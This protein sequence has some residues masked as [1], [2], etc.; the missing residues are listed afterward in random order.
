MLRRVGRCGRSRRCPS[1][2][3]RSCRIF[4]RAISSCRSEL[5][6]RHIARR[7]AECRA[8]A[9]A[10]KC[11]RCPTCEIVEQQVGRAELGEDT[12]GPHRSEFH[13]ELKAD[14]TVDQS[15][16]SGSN[17]A[18]SCSTI[19]GCRARWS[20]FSGDR[21]SES[22]SGVDRAGGDQDI[23]R[24]PRRARSNSAGKVVAALGKVK[25][26]VDLQFKRQS[27]TPGDLHP[28]GS[29]GAGGDRPQGAGRSRDHRDG[30]CGRQGRARRFR[31]PVPSMSWCC[32]PTSVRHQPAQ[33][34]KADDRTPL[35]P[36]PLS[37]VANIEVTRTVTASSTTAASGSSP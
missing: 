35:G 3:A 23:R 29:A 28:A 4:A 32:C 19:P 16:G 14:A 20:R 37:Q 9:S 36:V 27:G 13:V 2:A 11:W 8:S 21:I 15:G 6:H 24:R 17:C 34:A 33:L 18:A 30:V 12:W 22:L 26:I 5:R 25:G 31:A 10:R 1:W 7:D